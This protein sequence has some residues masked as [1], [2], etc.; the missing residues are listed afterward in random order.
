MACKAMKFQSRMS[1]KRDGKAVGERGYKSG[2]MGHSA[3]EKQ[4]GVQKMRKGLTAAK[5]KHRP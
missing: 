2:G 3:G 1:H 5:S 4:M